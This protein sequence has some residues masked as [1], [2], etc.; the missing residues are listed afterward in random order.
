MA[1]GHGRIL[2]SV[3]EDPDFIEMTQ[4]QQRFYFFLISQP[5]LNHAGLLPLTLKRWSKKA[6]DLSVGAV[7]QLLA[8]L[9]ERRFIAVDDDTE[10]LLIRT[11]V[12]NDGVWKQPKVMAA[13]VSG[14]AEISSLKL[15]RVLLAEMDRLPLDELS[16]EPGARGVSV[17]QQVEEHVANVRRTLRVPDPQPPSN[18]SGRVSDTPSDPFRKPSDTP[19]E[20]FG[21]PSES[22]GEPTTRAH[23]RASR[24]HSPAPAPAPAPAPN[25]SVVEVGEETSGSSALAATPPDGDAPIDIDGFE[26]TDS[27]RAW[28]LRTF[29]PGLDLD[30]ETAQFIDHFRA[31]NTRRPN[32]PAEWQKWIR[33]SAKFASERAARPPLRSV[34]GKSHQPYEPP[35]D[36]SVYE[37]GFHAHA[38]PQAAGE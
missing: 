20:A 31:Q 6:S 19:S 10:E 37:N 23:A 3:W 5:N 26:L 22:L 24:A 8:D 12:R 35:T 30:Y 13:M 4:D 25:P 14:A 33:R 11:F 2:A 27:M 9:E 17:R 21:K 7:E 32:W 16:S 38:R 1:R 29:G 34:G 28:A 18:P 15:R 36:L